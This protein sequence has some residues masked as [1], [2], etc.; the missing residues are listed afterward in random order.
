MA[1]AAEALLVDVEDPHRDAAVLARMPALEGVE[2]GV[3][4]PER[5][6]QLG[7][8]RRDAGGQ[9]EE[10]ETDGR[11]SSAGAAPEG[12]PLSR[13]RPPSSAAGLAEAGSH[14][15]DRDSSAR[16]SRR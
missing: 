12:S 16:S 5:E 3:P 1:D 14:A 4:E 6:R 13:R 15:A 11:E 2:R 7:D 9:Q 8:V 10:R